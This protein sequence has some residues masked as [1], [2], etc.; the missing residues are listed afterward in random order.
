MCMT[1]TMTCRRADVVFKPWELLFKELEDKLVEYFQFGPSLIRS[2]SITP[3]TEETE[4]YLAIINRS[5]APEIAIA[6]QINGCMELRRPMRALY[7]F[8]VVSG[9]RPE[10]PSLGGLFEFQLFFTSAQLATN[11]K[12]TAGSKTDKGA[13]HAR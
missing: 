13:Y 6:R 3:L 11:N 12:F 10:S 5:E 8:S 4:N 9:R 1:E 7:D 2:L